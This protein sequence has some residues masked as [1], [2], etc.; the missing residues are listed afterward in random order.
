VLSVAVVLVLVLS[1]A[2]GVWVARRQHRI[3]AVASR[4]GQLVMSRP[5]S[6]WVSQRGWQQ[7]VARRLGVGEAAALTLAAGLALVVALAVGFT[8]LLDSVLEGDGITAVD[9]PAAR[10]VAGHR[11]GW[12]T[13]AMRVITHAGD[14]VSVAVLAAVVCVGM[15]WWRRSWLPLVLG[16]LGAG[17]IGL[18]V[19][20]V[21]LM[22]GRPRPPLPFAAIAED[23]Y[24]F[25]S[26]H[27]TGIMVAVAL[28]GWMVTRWVIRSWSGRVL[29]WTAAVLLIGV[30]GFSRVYLGVHY[31]SDVAAGWL[32]GA[33]WAGT[34]VQAGGWWDSAHGAARTPPDGGQQSLDAPADGASGPPLHAGS[35]PEPSGDGQ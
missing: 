24:S 2:A 1:A 35:R 10:W 23:G 18:V 19:M 30:V 33:V 26:G 29:V 14:P 5:V 6:R 15:A 34:L 32:L 16:V 31:L 17:G 11:D 22:V 9:Q 21:K 13:A 3:A 25:P 28:T 12:L 4:F 8:Y 7:A 27:A 20:A